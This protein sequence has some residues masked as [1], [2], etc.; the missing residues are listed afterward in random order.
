MFL[1]L[2][3]GELLGAMVGLLSSLGAVHGIL[4]NGITDEPIELGSDNKSKGDDSNLDTG[5]ARRIVDSGQ[6]GSDA[7]ILEYPPVLSNRTA[8]EHDNGA[9]GIG[10]KSPRTAKRQ[11]SAS[12]PCNS[13]LRRAS[14]PPLPHNEDGKGSRENI[15]HSDPGES[16]DDDVWSTRREVSAPPGGRIAPNSRYKRSRRSPSPTSE[17]DAEED[18]NGTLSSSTDGKLASTA[19]TTPASESAPPTE[20]QL[21]PQVI[22]ADRDW[23]VRQIIGKEDVDGVLHYLVDWYPTLLPEHSLGHAKELVDKFEARLRAQ[24]EANNGRGGQGLKRGE[25]A[26]VEADASGGQQQKRPRGWPRKQ[27]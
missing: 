23:E 15:D 18:D 10:N 20:P 8:N 7:F 12:P 25:R 19:R 17:E 4:A 26:V 2:M 27:T 11:R 3:N 14:T 16:G 9:N 13:I 22:D 24:R 5:H 6:L 21:C 1:V